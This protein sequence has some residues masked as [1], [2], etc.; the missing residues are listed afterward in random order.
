MKRISKEISVTITVYG[1]GTAFFDYLDPESGDF[2]SR[3][4]DTESMWETEKESVGSEL[5]SWAS[6]MED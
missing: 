1:N 4:T 3:K 2:I 5:L 6:L